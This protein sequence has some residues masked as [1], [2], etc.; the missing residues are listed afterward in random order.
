MSINH[1]IIEIEKA[2]IN[3]NVDF[4]K[5]NNTEINIIEKI[6]NETENIEYEIK[7]QL[8]HIESYSYVKYTL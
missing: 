6:E 1:L 2:I 4:D 8:Q 3:I 5:K 7:K